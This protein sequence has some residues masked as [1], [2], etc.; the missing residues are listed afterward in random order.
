M[1]N[2]TMEELSGMDTVDILL[3]LDG[4]GGIS[5]FTLSLFTL[6][7]FTLSLFTQL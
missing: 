4:A 6:S 5:L 1:N 3:T 7:L 2:L